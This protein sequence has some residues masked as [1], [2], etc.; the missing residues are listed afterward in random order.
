MLGLLLIFSFWVA[1]TILIVLPLII[2]FALGSRLAEKLGFDGFEYYLF[3][4]FFY[5]IILCL[6]VIL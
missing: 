1:I 3:M 6:L 5:L 2:V 4:I